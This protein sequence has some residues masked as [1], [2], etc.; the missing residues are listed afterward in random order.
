MPTILIIGGYGN[1]G[2]YIADLPLQHTDAELILAGRNEEK[3]K[4]AASRLRAR[5]GG[6]VEA[7]RLDPGDEARLRDAF[8]RCDL[9]VFAASTHKHYCE[10]QI[11]SKWVRETEKNIDSAFL[12][13]ESPHAVLSFNEA[14]ALFGR[15]GEVR[16]SA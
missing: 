11:V 3:A 12:E 4:A 10:P 8:A 7:L 9:A 15:R 6:E 14:D 2:Y 16:Q 5:H 1:T 13:V